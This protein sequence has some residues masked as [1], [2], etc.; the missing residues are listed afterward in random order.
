[1]EYRIKSKKVMTRLCLILIQKKKG[2]HAFDEQK[3]QNIAIEYRLQPI[4]A[5]LLKWH[6]KRDQNV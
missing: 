5:T 4:F 1:M 6:I 2:F 3:V